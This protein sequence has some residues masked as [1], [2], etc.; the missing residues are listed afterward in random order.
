M[1]NFE[2]RF[3]NV[4]FLKIPEFSDVNRQVQNISQPFFKAILRYESHLSITLF[5]FL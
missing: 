5:L 3:S 1:S 2:I 4:I